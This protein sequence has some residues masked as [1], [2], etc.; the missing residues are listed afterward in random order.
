[1]WGA[2]P[3]QTLTLKAPGMLGV[4]EMVT[5]GA[6][7]ERKESSS[8]GSVLVSV[9]SNQ[10]TDPSYSIQHLSGVAVSVF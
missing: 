4:G 6:S 10:A 1:M 9:N 5:A 8:K 2:W 7:K 3:P